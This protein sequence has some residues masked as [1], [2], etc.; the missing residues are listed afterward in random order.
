MIDRGVP[1]AQVFQYLMGSPDYE[2][3]VNG[4]YNFYNNY[5]YPY[6]TMSVTDCNKIQDMADLMKRINSKY[7]LDTSLL[8][9]IQPFYD[10]G[11]YVRH[12]CTDANLLAEFEAELKELV[13]FAKA[14]EYVY[15]VAPVETRLRIR[16]FSGLSISDP[17]ENSL[18]ES[19]TSTSWYLATH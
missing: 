5:H 8:N 15:C 11:D 10:Y 7:T 16:N 9:Q 13:P 1:Y 3:F 4:F 18:A 6:G 14:T 2:R 19:K 12:L 17:S